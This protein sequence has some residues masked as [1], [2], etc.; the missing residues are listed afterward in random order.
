[1]PLFI[2]S[3][4][5]YPKSKARHV[6][7]HLFL[8]LVSWNADGMAGAQAAILS[9]ELETHELKR[10]E[11]SVQRAWISDDFGAATPSVGCSPPDLVYMREQ[12]N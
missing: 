9:H 5:K 11:Q 3:N 12:K 1:M 10:V 6:S 2:S 4:Q 7:F 8:L